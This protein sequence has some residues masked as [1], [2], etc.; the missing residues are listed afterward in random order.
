MPSQINLLYV[1]STTFALNFVTATDD[2]P[3]VC[4]RACVR[5]CVLPA[6]HLKLRSITMLVIW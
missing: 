3:T 6:M 1:N 4:V 2:V 5:A